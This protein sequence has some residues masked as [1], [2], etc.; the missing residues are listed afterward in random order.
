[1][2]CIFAYLQDEYRQ[3]SGQEMQN[4]SG[5][6]FVNNQEGIPRQQ[7]GHDCGVFMLLYA[8]FLS[9]DLPLH[10]NQTHIDSFREK[11]CYS[12]ITGKLWY[13]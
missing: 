3:N 7:N 4:I 12:I 10:F 1:M 13:Q 8:D 5:W 9:E 2:A 11:I 6:Q